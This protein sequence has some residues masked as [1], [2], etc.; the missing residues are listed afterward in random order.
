MTDIA[1]RHD[2]PRCPFCGAWPADA[3]EFYVCC[4]TPDC[5]MSKA[6]CIEIDVWQRRPL[7]REYDADLAHAREAAAVVWAVACTVMHLVELSEG[8]ALP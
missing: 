2:L 1:R 6:G 3:G 5:P 4:V 8:E 7:E